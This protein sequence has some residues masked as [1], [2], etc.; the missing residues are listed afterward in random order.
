LVFL[1]FIRS[2]VDDEDQGVLI[3]LFIY[4]FVTLMTEFINMPKSGNYFLFFL[5]Y[6]KYGFLL[7]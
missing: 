5:F 7:L 1:Q 4:L 2:F 6:W 3:F